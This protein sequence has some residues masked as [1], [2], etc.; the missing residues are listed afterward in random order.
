MS[1]TTQVPYTKIEDEAQ[2]TSHDVSYT[3]TIRFANR[4]INPEQREALAKLVR[5]RAME[6]SVFTT[7]IAG[8]SMVK[9]ATLSR[10]SSQSGRSLIDYAAEAPPEE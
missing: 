3:F 2:D 10:V 1:Y 9:E 7:L 5:Q 4:G 8:A 6:I